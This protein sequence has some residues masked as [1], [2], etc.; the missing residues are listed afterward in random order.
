MVDD[1]IQSQ[2]SLAAP[3]SLHMDYLRVCERAVFSFVQP[4]G[5]YRALHLGVAAGCFVR[6][7]VS[8]S[9]RSEHTL[10]DHAPEVCEPV[11]RAVPLPAHFRGQFFY[12]DAR[13]ALGWF[14]VTD[15]GPFDVAI[16]DLWSGNRVQ[17]HVTSWEFYR[18][19]ARQLSDAALLIVNV[20]DA[21]GCEFGRRQAATLRALFPCLSVAGHRAVLTG[22]RPGNLVLMASRPGWKHPRADLAPAYPQANSATHSVRGDE[23]TFEALDGERLATWIGE[24]TVVTDANA[25]GSPVF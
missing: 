4:G 22:K 17:A 13:A 21:P 9:P 10:V 25:T 16:V 12:E 14:R 2:F 7:L 1:T 15:R 11:L 19:V 5:S 6:A 8:R 18:S 20:P 23:A 24:A 3:A